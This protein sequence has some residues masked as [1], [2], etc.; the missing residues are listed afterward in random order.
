LRGCTLRRQAE[1]DR[2]YPDLIPLREVLNRPVRQELQTLIGCFCEL[3][4]KTI[5][6]S[7]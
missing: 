6:A 5:K 3:L 4:P 7:T 2:K 1:V